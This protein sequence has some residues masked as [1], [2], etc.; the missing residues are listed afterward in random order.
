MARKLG[1]LHGK[2]AEDAEG[3][4][5]LAMRSMIDDANSLCL[6]EECR[7][8]EEFYGTSFTDVTNN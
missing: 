1:F 8:L 7:D 3:V 6:V 4:G 2:L 5:A